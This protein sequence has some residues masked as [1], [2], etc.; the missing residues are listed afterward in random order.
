[1]AP[2]T[3]I[4][5]RFSSWRARPN[6]APAAWSRASEWPLRSTSTIA[7]TI[8][9]LKIL[10]LFTGS[11]ERFAN[12]AAVL[13]WTA[14]QDERSI[15]RRAPRSCGVQ[16]STRRS[17]LSLVACRRAAKADSWSPSSKSVN[18]VNTSSIASVVL[19][20]GELVTLGACSRPNLSSTTAISEEE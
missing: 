3:P 1:M 13:I 9:D 7:G 16:R 8:P 12:A 4:V 19:R 17:Q 11:S 15:G 2:K 6:K 20:E 18:L 10:T 14:A 5:V